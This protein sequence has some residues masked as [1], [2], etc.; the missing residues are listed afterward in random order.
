ME[1]MYHESLSAIPP[2][3]STLLEEYSH[4]P[5]SKQI[6]H[7]L[8][9]RN[10]A[11]K[12]HP[13]P[14]LGRFRFLELDLTEHP[15]YESYVLPS[16]RAAGKLLE[17][18]SGS[19]KAE[20]QSS[21]TDG[22][23]AAAIQDPIFLDL[24]TCLGQDLRKLAFDGAPVSLLYGSDIEAD[25]IETGYELF[26]DRSTFPASHF[27]CPANVF[28]NTPSNTLSVLDDR[29]SILQVSAVFHLFGLDKQRDVARRCLKL[30]KK[31]AGKEVLVLGGQAGAVSARMFSR[32]GRDRFRHDEDSWRKMWDGVCAEPAWKET[33]KSLKVEVWMSERT[34]KEEADD[35]ELEKM[36]GE[37]MRWMR[38]AVWVTF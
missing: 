6:E 29:V 20:V 31:D 33:V 16:L 30:L 26:R 28:D 8:S 19:G 36:M 24:G 13:Y 4:V 2:V 34:S 23:T 1:R 21:N 37:G 9:L 10:R 18:N 5:Q 22:L 25:F 14:C 38:F 15:L 3:T 32:D 12:S 27:L 11:Y 17:L 7:V 35:K